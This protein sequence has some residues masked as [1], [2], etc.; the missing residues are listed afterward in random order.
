MA[1]KR[2]E[3][4][5]IDDNERITKRNTEK[6]NEAEKRMRISNDSVEGIMT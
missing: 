5:K 4:R 3:K 1:T 6:G 2:T